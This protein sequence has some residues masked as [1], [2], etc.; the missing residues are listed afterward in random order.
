MKRKAQ[1]IEKAKLENKSKQAISSMMTGFGS[2][3]WAAG[4]AHHSYSCTKGCGHSK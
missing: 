1:E 4:Q 3:R 2:S